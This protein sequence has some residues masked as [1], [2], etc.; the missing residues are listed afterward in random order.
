MVNKVLTSMFHLTDDRTCPN[1]NR[2]MIRIRRKPM[3]R[4]LSLVVPVIRCRC[5]GKDFLVRHAKLETAFQATAK[6]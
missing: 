4:A 1:C 5:C 3:D 2:Q 6:Q